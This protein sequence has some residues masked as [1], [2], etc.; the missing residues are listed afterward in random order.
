MLWKESVNR[1]KRKIENKKN[2]KISRTRLIFLFSAVKSSV[3]I[4]L[5]SRYVQ[6]YFSGKLFYTIFLV[7]MTVE[8]IPVHSVQYWFQAAADL[9]QESAKWTYQAHHGQ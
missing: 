2:L 6:K 5:K 4:Y 7:K 8:W 3:N 9:G 1:E